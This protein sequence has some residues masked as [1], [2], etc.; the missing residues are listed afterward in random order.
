MARWVSSQFLQT[1]H[2]SPKCCYLERR[3]LDFLLCSISLS[4]ALL[5]PTCAKMWSF[6]LSVTFTCRA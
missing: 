5:K 1:L 3:E 2:C 4:M 6:K